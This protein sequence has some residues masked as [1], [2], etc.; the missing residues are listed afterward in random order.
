MFCFVRIVSD[1]NF[2]EYKQSNFAKAA[3]NRTTM[4]DPPPPPV[5]A[6]QLKLPAFFRKD[7]EI[8]FNLIE[9]QFTLHNISTDQTK[10]SHLCSV[11]DA[12]VASRVRT[13]IM[14]PPEQNKYASLKQAIIKAFGESDHAKMNRLMS[15]M[16]LG[17][18]RPSELL[19]DMRRLA[20]TDQDSQMLKTLWLQK[21]PDDI[22]AIVACSPEGTDQAEQA[23]KAFDVKHQYVNTVKPGTPNELQEL[24]D[25]ITALQRSLHNRD[26]STTLSSKSKKYPNERGE[27]YYHERFG[28]K[29]RKCNKPCSY[30]S[31]N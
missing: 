12:E 19:E 24:K 6:V 1:N 31:K 15:S 22:R 26:R 14:S 27:C 21:L 29:A 10:F 8:W 9:T 5:Y 4:A 16:D 25:Q 11:L 7:P 2:R 3:H 20:G 30:P 13:K 28:A 18:R 17:D 23:D